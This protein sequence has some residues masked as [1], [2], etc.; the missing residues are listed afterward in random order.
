[1]S[2]QTVQDRHVQ[3]IRTYLPAMIAVLIARI[4]AAFPAVAHVVEV[5]DGI[6]IEAGWLGVSVTWLVQAALVALIL[7]AYQ[8]AAQRLGDRWPKVE[9]VMLGSAQRPTYTGKHATE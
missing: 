6:F 3:L 1:M 7:L 2:I 4:L 8:R 9:A 5:I